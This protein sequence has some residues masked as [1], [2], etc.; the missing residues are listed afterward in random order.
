MT[1]ATPREAAAWWAQYNPPSE[2]VDFKLGSRSRGRRGVVYP[3]ITTPDGIAV[4]QGL[5]CEGEPFNG[6]TGCWHSKENSPMVTSQALVRSEAI[7][8]PAPIAFTDAQLDV[9]KESIAKGASDEELQLFVATCTRTGL[10][11][12]MR[13]IYFVKRWDSRAGKEVGA[14]QVGIDGMRLTAERTGKYAGQ[15]TTEYL[16]ENGNWSEVWLGKGHPIAAKAAVYRKDWDRPAIAICRWDSYAQTY[17]KNNETHLMPNWASM[18]DVMLGKCAESLA[19]RRAFPAEMSALAAAAG[20]GTY[21][22]EW[23]AQAMTVAVDADPN[24]IESTGRVVAEPASNGVAQQREQVDDSPARPATAEQ[25]AAAAPPPEPEAP[26]PLTP[27]DV[28]KGLT[29]SSWWAKVRGTGKKP[30]ELTA[31][32]KEVYGREPKDLGDAERD[33]LLERA[34]N[35]PTPGC[36]HT[37]D[38]TYTEDGDL[39]CSDCGEL[40]DES[41]QPITA[42]AAT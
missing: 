15:D 3:M 18:P 33:A 1:T 30:A 32:A 36:A 11:P 34:L 37:G 9:I 38:P 29:L 6:P 40:L 24:V 41:G 14:I 23:D 7:L 12:F 22:P 8:S 31:L 25:S 21:D 17:K 13:Q 19:L 20:D 10:D 27:A 4:H 5:G 16:D 2:V 42:A 39:V 35:P 26:A 28:A